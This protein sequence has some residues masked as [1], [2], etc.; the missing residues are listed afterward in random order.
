MNFC[1]QWQSLKS[2]HL[3][4]NSH[5]F[6][7]RKNWLFSRKKKL[8]TK[9]K[10]LVTGNVATFVKVRKKW[11][12]PITKKLLNFMFSSQCMDYTRMVP[13]FILHGLLA[14]F[15]SLLSLALFHSLYF[16]SII[17]FV[18]SLHDM[19]KNVLF[20]AT[21]RLVLIKHARQAHKKERK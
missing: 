6:R 10:L 13:P 9:M 5:F 12:R 8:R 20:R 18:K 17:N 3:C 7:S 11:C 15:S 16:F 21:R 19:K 1:H 4:R 2:Q 14:S